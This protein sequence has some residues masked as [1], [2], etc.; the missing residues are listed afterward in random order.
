MFERFTERAR[1]VVVLAQDEGRGLGHNYIGTEHLLLGLLREEEGLGA[2]VLSSLGITVEEVRA[3]VARIVGQG[4]EITTGQIPFTPRAKK[5]LELALRESQSLGHDFIGTEHLL[6]GLAADPET[7]AGRVLA[8]LDVGDVEILR[9][10]V[11]AVVGPSDDIA[12]K[13]IPFTPRAKRVLELSLREALSLGVDYI[14][15]EHIL[16]GLARDDQGVANAVLRDH[17]VDAEHVRNEVMRL[18]TTSEYD[19]VRQ[20]EGASAL[21]RGPGGPVLALDSTLMGRA[22]AEAKLREARAIDVGDLV[23]ADAEGAESVV[24]EALERAGVSR[25]AFRAALAAA[26]EQTADSGSEEDAG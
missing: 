23:L 7:A 20:Y 12:S 10:N 8:E 1:Q 21:I 6:L 25:D 19:D 15:T 11:A 4:D 14:G 17:G 26:R 13:Q 5:V 2:R 3:Q 18:V 9:A 16:L 24:A 22:R